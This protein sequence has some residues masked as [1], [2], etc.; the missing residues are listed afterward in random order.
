MNSRYILITIIATLCAVG[1]HQ[2][3]NAG[4]KA[5]PDFQLSEGQVAEFDILAP[6]DFPILKT[7]AQIQAEYSQKLAQMVQ[8]YM[9]SPDVEFEAYSNLDRFFGLIYEAAESSDPG[10]VVLSARQQGY[11]L[12]RSGLLLT[13][14]KTRIASSQTRVKRALEELYKAGIYSAVNGDSIMLNTDRGVEKNSLA[15]HFNIEEAKRLI[16]QR[17]EPS[18][19][20]LVEL[21]ADKLILPNLVV[22]AQS[23]SK[24]Q[25]RLFDSI[26]PVEGMVKQNEAIIRRNQRLTQEDVN[27]VRSLAREYEARGERRSILNQWLG[28]MGLLL[29]ML[30]VF[31]T[32]N[33]HL[34]HTPVKETYG[35]AG[36]IVLNAGLLGQILFTLLTYQLFGLNVSLV[37]FSLL[38]ITVAILLG[39]DLGILFA[40]C[41]SLLLG[42][43]LN[44]DAAS[45][46]LLLLSSLLTLALI[47]RYK[48]RH[49]FI[50]IWIFLFVSVN[51]INAALTLLAFNG[52][53]LVERIQA[54]MRN[55]GYSLVSTTLS[56]LGCLVLVTFFERKWNRA[57]KQI[58]LE[59]L[60]FNHPLLKRLAT[61]AVGTYHHSLIVGNLAE[62]AAESIGANPLLARVGSYFHDIGKTVNPE[63]FTENNE[64]SAE[65]YEKYSPEESAD[66]I[67]DH[68]KEGVVLAEKHRVPQLVIDIIWQHHGTSYIRFFLDAAQRQGEVVDPSAF[69]YPGPLP[70]TKEA[71]LVMLA[72]VV[73]STSKSRKDASNE[74]ISRMIDETIQRLIRDGQLDEAPITIQDLA[75]AK[76]AMFPIL[77]SVYRKRLEYPEDRIS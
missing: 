27:K 49:Q 41:S 60:D 2:M 32:F 1:L 45:L 6:F 55:A 42:P 4:R 64:D 38:I 5:Y 47:R 72:D 7:E 18:L 71:A 26:D 53:N 39:F 3:T 13:G 11:Q 70:R 14:D 29:V 37:P 46:T 36:V 75:K 50:M 69:R 30:A 73:E 51:L 44:W 19:A 35:T 17:L 68:V 59:L 34:W 23:Y 33:I 76:T 22:D 10:A 43:F 24:E 58:L 31:F 77:E 61:N 48:T 15:R 63:I 52:E 8:P 54:L 9:L 62:R 56:V 74:D 57:T 12:E 28:V 21:N 25:Q 40:I 66:I 67:R 16:L 20:M 65:Y